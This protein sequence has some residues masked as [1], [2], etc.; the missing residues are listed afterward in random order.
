MTRILVS[1]IGLFFLSCSSPLSISD[2]SDQDKTVNIDF[3]EFELGA[4]SKWFSADT[5]SSI[6]STALVKQIGEDI[7]SQI[8]IGYKNQ[9]GNYKYIE[10]AEVADITF[11]VKSIDVKRRSFTFNFLKPGP[12]YLMIIKT[13]I[14]T[15]E[16]VTNSTTKKSLTNM[17]N[18][19]FPDDNVKWMSHEEKSNTDNQIKT[20]RE[21]LRRLYQNLYFDAFDISLRL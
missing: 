5:K 21:G 9:I 11:K 12:L 19:V 3:S 17:V 1:I 8:V 18:V 20:F 6:D 16:N 4:T 2:D 15:A 14:L 10:N 13:D 7:L